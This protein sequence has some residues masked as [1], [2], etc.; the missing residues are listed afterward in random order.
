MKISGQSRRCGLNWRSFAAVLAVFATILFVHTSPA[1]AQTVTYSY[2]G[3]PFDVA[4][5]LATYGTSRPCVSGSVTGS[6]TFAI[7]AGY[8]GSAGQNSVVSYV[9]N[10]PGVGSD[11]NLNDLFVFNN[12]SFNNGQIVDWGFYA[13]A[14]VYGGTYPIEYVLYVSKYSNASAGS[15]DN[16]Y[17][18]EL[19]SGPYFAYGQSFFLGPNYH[20]SSLG[21][22]TNTK[23]LGPS[24]GLPGAV[25]CTDPIDLGSGN[26]YEHVTDYETAGQNKLAFTRYY[27]SM[28]NPD[29]FATVLGSNWRSNYDRYL[30]LVSGTGV[31]AE[32]ADGQV[33]TFTLTGGVWKADTDIDLKLTSS[34][35]T[36]TLTDHDDTVETYAAA[37]SVATLGTIKLRNG[38]TETMHYTAGTLTSVTDSYG[39]AL[40]FAYTS[41]LLHTVTTPDSLVLTYA[42]TTVGTANR[43]TSVSYN[44]SPAT[45][46]TYLY[47]NASYPFAL[48]GITDE[49]GNRYATWAYSGSGRAISSQHG[50]GADLTQI[51]YDDATGNRTVTGPLGAVEI[52]KF[53]TLQGVPKVTEIDRVANGTVAAATRLFTY[54][55]NGYRA[56]ETDWNGNLT[57]YTND[58]HGQPTQIVNASGSPVA[59]T[60]TIAY[61]P[62]WAHLAKTITTPGLT[63]V[64]NYDATTGNLLTR[65]ETDTTTQTSPYKTS[66]QARTWTYTW[67]ATGQLLTLRL[68]RADVTAK[69]TFGYTGGTLTSTTD[70]LGH[71]TTINTFKPGGLPLT[72]TDP[73]G[74]VE[75]RAYNARNWLTSSVLATAAGNLTTGITY[76][77]A[78]N[79]TKT[80][81]PDNSYLSYAYDTAHRRTK[82]TNPLTESE[83]FTLDAQGNVTQILWKNAS[84]TTTRQHTATFDALGRALT[85]VGGMSQTTAF[86]YDS[87]SNDLSITDPLLHVSQQT[88]DALNRLKSATDV[89]KDLS[90]YTYDAHDRPLTVTDPRGKVTSYVYDGFGE[91]IQQISP[92]TGTTVW[93]YDAD[94]N[95]A[96]KTDAASVVT[97][98]TYDALDRILTRTYPA[99]STLNV[100][101]TYDQASHGKGIGR[102]TSLTDQS[103]SL[104]RSYEERGL[105]TSDARTISSTVYTTTTTYDAAGRIASIKY[106]T[107]GWIVGY[108]RDAAGRV[109]AVTATQ[110]GHSAVNLATAV[111]HLPFGPVSG[112]AWGNGVTDA[113]TFDLDARMTRV[114]DT[115]TAVI[116]SLT[117]TYDA[118]NNVKTIND[119]VTPANNQ[120]LNYDKLDRLSSG[121]GGYSTGAI[122]FD[123][124]SNRLTYGT[125]TYSYA[126]TSNWLT[127][128]GT[129]AV[130][131]TATGNINAIGTNTMTYNKANQLATATVSGVTS[132][133]GYDAFG[134]RLK[135]TV[136]ANPLSVT[137]YGQGNEILTETNANVETDYA[138]L[139]GIPIAAIQPAAAT[140][141]YIHSDRLGTPQKAT[142]AAKTIVWSGNYLPFGAVTP[143]G[144]VTQNLRFPGMYADATGYYHNGARDFNPAGGYLEPD[145]LGLVAGLNP[146][147]YARQNPFKWTDRSGLLPTIPQIA[148]GAGFGAAAGYQVGKTQ[149]ERD[150]GALVGAIAGG[151]AALITPGL[152]RFAG[153]EAAGI[154]TTLI[155]NAVAAGGAAIVTNK[156]TGNP[157]TLGLVNAVVI[158]TGASALS[159]ELFL[160]GGRYVAGVGAE[161]ALAFNTGVI[162][163]GGAL[164]DAKREQ[165]IDADTLKNS[166]CQVSSSNSQ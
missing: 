45:S 137:E 114:I 97:N 123:S 160:V 107:G 162:G 15:Y 128:A 143:T 59:H 155:A 94:G 131:H 13:G 44:T 46:Q 165:N 18:E 72:T 49:N 17:F 4:A 134:Q 54:D 77:S 73:N 106:P 58:S 158:Q 117:Y 108:V 102:L 2:S 7:P 148:I 127:K 95:V 136:G 83:N 89:V 141:S 116:E 12:F 62:T 56:S 105:V 152:S 27:N 64:N 63:T 79:L 26:V 103:G 142:N 14:A 1:S 32:R 145:P 22:W 109:S 157:P 120:T 69:T 111:K 87:Q 21:V 146:Y 100:A 86:G 156:I 36:W 98:M 150:V 28:A 96:S 88:F 48:T 35:S 113:R 53:T 151:G 78:G 55:T 5:C 34:G 20:P 30:H 132:T 112:F 129:S 42:F 91:V 76:D 37:G 133:Y 161:N 139:D 85:D 39:R 11:S 104:S 31:Q 125:T 159:G 135:A 19:P 144:T 50:S 9:L 81:L 52:Y 43:L 3:P 68:P 47:E 29:T 153:G 67:N 92:D 8:S 66:G 51:A 149:F 101:F 60:T 6:V 41:S 75:T 154:A 61:D 16:A 166:A 99:D 119:A 122:T 23:A 121:T 82:I 33:I 110:P 40:T 140:I 74:V 164:I 93:H 25:S 57:T 130:T 24:C 115:G 124:N 118:D 126:T 10:A 138:W 38:Y 147:N 84:G 71:V 163:L 80:T 65:V 90:T 70:A